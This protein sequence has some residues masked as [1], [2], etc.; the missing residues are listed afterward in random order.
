MAAD[1][2]GETDTSRAILDRV[3]LVRGD[4]REISAA[5]GVEVSDFASA[6][7]AAMRLL[8]HGPR[9]AVVEAGGEGDL[10]ATRQTELRV[11][12]LPITV[13]Y[14]TGAGDALITTLAVL[15][16]SDVQLETAAGLGSAA[17]AHTPA[18]SAGGRPTPVS[19]SS[20]RLSV[21]RRRRGQTGCFRNDRRRPARRRRD[22]RVPPVPQAC[23]TQ[24]R[25]G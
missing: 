23:G 4:A 2:A 14:P 25:R 13:V 5:T 3:D 19:E 10:I 7:Q 6:A 24:Q 18:T 22:R 12:R 8:A 21:A 11:P 9:I 20:R 15:L 16:A 1:L 17:A